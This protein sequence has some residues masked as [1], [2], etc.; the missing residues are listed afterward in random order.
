MGANVLTPGGSVAFRVWAPNASAVLLLLRSSDAD[1]WALLPLKAD[2]ATGA[3]WSADISGVAMGDEFRF[4]ITN[5]EA[6]GP[7]NPGGD[8]EHVDPRARQ[9]GA[10][11]ETSPGYVPAP[12]V[13]PGFSAFQAP[14]PEDLIIYQLHVGSFRGKNDSLEPAGGV[15]QFTDVIAKLPYIRGMNFNAVQFLPNGAYPPDQ[16]EGY[17]PTNFFAPEPT[18]GVPGELRQLVDACHRAGL[19]VFFDVIYN[20][21][22]DDDNNLWQFDGNQSNWNGGGIYVADVAPTPHRR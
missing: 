8:V 6:R 18:E 11:D 21:F 10:P 4:R 22:P 15:A 12:P 1:D 7:D 16:P 5:D 20:H 14:A 2:D 13:A 9:V 3:Y 17:A 19:A